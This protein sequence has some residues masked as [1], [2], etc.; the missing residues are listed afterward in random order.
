MNQ[1]TMKP[2][3]T[4]YL[5]WNATAPVRPEVAA[6]IAEALQA[7]GNPSSVHRFGRAARSALNTAREAVA[8]L[9]NAMPEEIVFTSG[10]TEANA[11]ALNGFAGR[12]LMISAIEHDSVRG[13]AAGAVVI[14]ASGDGRVDLV[15]LDQL[16]AA[17]PWPAGVAL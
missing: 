12:R 17:E 2:G 15:A 14:P 5:D 6:A 8:A 13:N 10:G 11:L 7:I 1:A 9:V 16:L 4:T 3:R